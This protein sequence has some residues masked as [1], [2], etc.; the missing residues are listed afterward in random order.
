MS[1]SLA[2]SLGQQRPQKDDMSTPKKKLPINVTFEIVQEQEPNACWFEVTAVLSW[3]AAAYSPR[4]DTCLVTQDEL[5]EIK[6]AICFIIGETFDIQ[7]VTEQTSPTEPQPAP[8]PDDIRIAVK[9]A[10]CS[11]VS[12]HTI[13]RRYL[14]KY[15]QNTDGTYTWTSE[16]HKTCP[17]CDPKNPD[18]YYGDE[19]EEQLRF[20][21]EHEEA[22]QRPRKGGKN[23]GHYPEGLKE[24]ANTP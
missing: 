9:C 1:L 10:T 19:T 17:Q 5:S 21:R 6:E 7:N 2:R 4:M 13:F 23:Y 11:H 12:E 18:V 16:K 3:E 14:W 20:L 22:R 15:R 24:G 8:E